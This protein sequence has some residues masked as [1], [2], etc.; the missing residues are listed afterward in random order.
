MTRVSSKLTV[1]LIAISCSVG[2]A[3][4]RFEAPSILRAFYSHSISLQKYK[5]LVERYESA[6]KPDGASFQLKQ[7]QLI[8]ADLEKKSLTI[9]G[10]DEVENGGVIER[11]L[12]SVSVSNGKATFLRS[13]GTVESKNSKK[14]LDTLKLAGE[15]DL[16]SI[17]HLPYPIPFGL[18]EKLDKLYAPAGSY[19]LAYSKNETTAKIV[20]DMPTKTPIRR[21]FWFDTYNSTPYKLRNTWFRK[22]TNEWIVS[23]EEDIEWAEQD[24]FRVPRRIIGFGLK[25]GVNKKGKKEYY[26]IDRELNLTWCSVN[27][28]I[29]DTEFAFVK[30]IRA[31]KKEI[32]SIR[33]SNVQD[34]PKNSE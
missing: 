7:V 30:D 1:F 26:R 28:D 24:G 16:R 2:Y 31:I 5:V 33:E 9:R 20:F 14:F 19:Q 21:T 34:D 29:R 4:D 17:G 13:D 32:S 10:F 27:K 15:T 22:N 6:V 11:G 3:G 12:K 8:F 25:S 23:H 18:F